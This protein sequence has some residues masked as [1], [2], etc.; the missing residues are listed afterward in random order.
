[1]AAQPG[2]DSARASAGV[3][4]RATI[5]MPGGLRLS[6]FAEA[7]GD[8]FNVSDL[9]PPNLGEERHVSAGPS[10]VAGVDVS[11]PL[12]R[13][14]GDR[15]IVLEPLLQVALSPDSDPD[16]LVANEDSSVLEFDETNLLTRQQVSGLRPLRG[17]PAGQ[18]RRAGDGCSMTT[19]AA[20]EPAGRPQLPGA[21]RIRSS[22]RAAACSPEVLRL[23]RG[24]RRRPGRRP[25]LL[26][27]GAVR[28]QR[29][30]TCG[31]WK[32]G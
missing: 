23:D 10:G 21:S 26:H 1:V 25:V 13:R 24:G 2:A 9:P 18:R 11:Y 3:D 5:T 17:R 16:P 22:R 12:Y 30:G 15:T 29:T 7:R 20:S 31:G 19:V 6:P 8:L 4:W 32:W 28:R 14:D 27:P